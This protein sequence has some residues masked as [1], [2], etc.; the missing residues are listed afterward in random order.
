[1]FGHDGDDYDEE[2]VSNEY[3]LRIAQQMYSDRYPTRHIFL[4]LLDMKC[5]RTEARRLCE[6][7]D[8]LERSRKQKDVEFIRY[9]RDIMERNRKERELEAERGRGSERKIGISRIRDDDELE[10]IR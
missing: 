8:H 4:K 10:R 5:D 7:V 6:Y 9:Q 3:F 2:I 1:M